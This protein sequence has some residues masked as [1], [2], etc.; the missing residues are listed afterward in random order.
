M[1]APPTL[2]IHANMRHQVPQKTTYL[3]MLGMP[4]AEAVALD[5]AVLG[6]GGQADGF[7]NECEDTVGFEVDM[8]KNARGPG[9]RQ[10][11]ALSPASSVDSRSRSWYVFAT[12][13][14]S[15]AVGS[16]PSFRAVSVFVWE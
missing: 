5:V 9:S 8:R 10:M 3:H 2:E 1:S 13:P 11:H 4:L 6:A 12:T 15:S 7:G 14:I 16:R